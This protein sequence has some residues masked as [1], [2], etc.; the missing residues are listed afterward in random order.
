MKYSIITINFNNKEGLERTI[1]SVINQTYKDYEYIIIDGNS[2][3]GSKDVIDQYNKYID[4]WVSEPDGG[5][6]DAMN[7]GTLVAHGDYC[8]YLNSGDCYHDQTVLEHMANIESEEDV[9]TGCHNEKIGRNIGRNGITMLDMFKWSYNHQESFIKR[10]LCVKY[11]YDI[12]YMIAA[13]RKFFIQI[14]IEENCTYKF[15]EKVVVDVEPGGTSNRFFSECSKEIDTILHEFLHPRIY[16]DYE[17]F[18]K[19]DSPLLALTPALNETMGIQKL[20][21]KFA[22]LLIKIRRNKLYLFI[23]KKNNI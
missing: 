1:K 12:K 4:Y 15:T 8:N 19:A 6:Y 10:S 13:D 9:L 5:I 16:V 3:D 21:Y 7:K 20:V 23:F 17:K 18:A 2:T 11:P 22:D 14:F